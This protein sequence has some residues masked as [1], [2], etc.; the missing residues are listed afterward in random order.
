ME[1]DVIPF[2]PPPATDE[3]EEINLGL[4]NSKIE[5]PFA[6]WLYA[7]PEN[8]VKIIVKIKILLRKKPF[9]I[10]YSSE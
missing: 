7:K 9:F 4:V 2:N 10:Y 6:V 8:V 1:E 3:A 5:F